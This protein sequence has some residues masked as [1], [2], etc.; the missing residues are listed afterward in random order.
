MLPPRSTANES[1]GSASVSVSLR[2][3]KVAQ[4]QLGFDQDGA[5]CCAP[6]PGG[7]DDRPNCS[8]SIGENRGFVPRHGPPASKQYLSRVHTSIQSAGKSQ[9][10]GAPIGVVSGAHIS[11]HVCLRCALARS[12]TGVVASY[13]DVICQPRNQSAIKVAQRVYDVRGSTADVSEPQETSNVDPSEYHM[14]EQPA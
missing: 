8:A 14:L 6:A 4:G 12:L 10:S 11:S 13:L 2:V 5:R 1:A 3:H 9:V 7:G